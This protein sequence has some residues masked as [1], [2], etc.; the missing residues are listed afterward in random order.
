MLKKIKFVALAAGLTLAFAAHAN[1]ITNGSFETGVFGSSYYYPNGSFAG[2]DFPS[3]SGIIDASYAFNAWWNGAAS[4][5]TGFDGSRYGF[6]QTTGS[7]SQTFTAGSSGSATLSWL[8]G[9]RPFN[10]SSNGD[11]TY[12]ILLNNNLIGTFSTAS[13]QAFTLETLDLGSLTQ[14]TSYTLKFQ[15]TNP[16]GTDNTAFLDRISVDFSA[17]PEP[18]T[19]ALLGLAGLALARRRGPA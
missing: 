11:Q 8:E 19:L 15:G 10:G 14:G 3:S 1:E 4:G 16:L 12:Q 6:V 13:G 7:L 18:G 5:P 9:S 17:V 2:W